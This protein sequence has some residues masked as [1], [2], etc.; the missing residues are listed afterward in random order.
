MSGYSNLD[1]F[2]FFFK[3]K[4]FM[5]FK[6]VPVAQLPLNIVMIAH[7]VFRLLLQ[8]TNNDGVNPSVGIFVEEVE[9]F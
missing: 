6:W 1:A 3:R 7:L 8:I 9:L 2:R 5:R 4:L